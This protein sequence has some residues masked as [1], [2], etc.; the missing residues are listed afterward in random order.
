M[1]RVRGG[2]EAGGG[3]AGEKDKQISGCGDGG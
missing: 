2:K 3:D 1:R